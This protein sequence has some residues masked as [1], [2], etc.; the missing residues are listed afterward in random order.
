MMKRPLAIIGFT[1]LMALV[2]AGIIGFTFSLTCGIVCL[3][4]FFIALCFK[5]L[6]RASTVPLVLFVI[7]IASFSYCFALSRTAVPVSA[8]AGIRT[9]VSGQILDDPVEEYG[10]YYYKIEVQNT[11]VKDAPVGFKLW[12][13]SKKKLEADA[14]DRLTATVQF[15]EPTAKTSYYADGYFVCAYVTGE[16]EIF[17]GDKPFYYNIIKMRR[18]IRGCIQSLLPGEEGA[19]LI[20]MLLGD[21]SYLS[22][23]TLDSFRR[24]GTSHLLAV[25]GLHLSAFCF[26]LLWLLKRLRLSQRVCSLA[27][28]AGV[29]FFMAL[30]GFSPSVQRAGIMMLIY[31]AGGLFGREPDGINSLGFSVLLLT[32]INPFAALDCSL[33]LSFS[34]TLGILVFSGAPL[35]SVKARVAKIKNRFLRRLVRNVAE[36]MTISFAACLFTMPVQLLVFGEISLVAL[37]S[38]L[39]VV[40]PATAA[41]L[42]GG[43]TVIFSS[44]WLSFLKY[45]FGLAAGL[46]AKYVLWCVKALADVPFAS[47]AVNQPYLQIWLGGTFVLFGLS[48]LLF[49]RLSRLRFTAWLSLLSLLVGM[50]SFQILN[51]GVTNIAVLDVGNGTCVALVNNGRAVLIGCGGENLPENVAGRYLRG[52]GIRE[53]DLLILPR[54]TQT[55]SSGLA[56]LLDSYGCDYLIL[57]DKPETEELLDAQRR[58]NGYRH[59]C[60][61]RT[62]TKIWGDTQIETD[63]A[64]STACVYIKVHDTSVLISSYPGADLNSL[65][66][67]WR[68]ADV[69]ICRGAPRASANGI[70][71]ETVI[72]SDNERGFMSAAV[73]QSRGVTALSTSGCGNLILSTR[74]HG[75]ISVVRR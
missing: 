53:L 13:S 40:F 49:R 14:F 33:L 67:E 24:A 64:D 42:C 52:M 4:A 19:V 66:Q 61:N 50:L 36:S 48:I 38:N 8:L 75:D 16:P 41:M 21:K 31:S 63:S 3:S 30:T 11:A 34:A 18:Y 32:L 7:C 68:S 54:I 60:N 55:E 27:A 74:G 70:S 56:P 45:P 9:Q 29:V 46:I 15:Y 37:I 58:L 72:I 43:L 2:T 28:M 17:E 20:G 10:R 12:L 25:S 44:G 51:F 23:E 69:F 71:A 6:R 47:A 22:A 26:M 59:I 35:Q 1:Y 62:S 5:N 39:L 57:P 65:P 73:E